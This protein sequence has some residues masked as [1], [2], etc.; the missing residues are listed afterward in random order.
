[1]LILNCL[2][3]SGAIN[4]HLGSSVAISSDGINIVV[5]APGVSSNRGAAYVY[6]RPGQSWFG[7]SK[8]VPD[9]TLTD[10]FS[11]TTDRVGSSV[12][13][14][15]DGSTIVAGA[16]DG[17]FCG[18]ALVFVRPGGSWSGVTKE[19][20]NATLFKLGSTFGDG[21]GYSVAISADGATI[22]A[23]AIGVNSNKGAAHVFVK[24]M[25]SDW[26]DDMTPDATLTNASAAAVEYLG[27][28]V[29]ISAD[30]STIVAGAD[31]VSG[32]KGAAYVYA[33]SGGSWINKSTP[34]AT[35]INSSGAANDFLG[36]S[37]AISGD[38]LTIVAGA[39]GVDGAYNNMGAA[40]VFFQQSNNANLS[41][42]VLSG[43]TLNPAFASGTTSYTADV[44]NSVASI[45]VTPTASDTNA[46]VRVNGT[47]VAS[48]SASGA[49]NLNVGAN[50][51]T[52]GVTAQDGVTTRTYTVTVTRA[53]FQSYLPL[54]MR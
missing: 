15:V 45:T 2:N 41:N 52:I 16:P 19:V 49:I 51:I 34:D 48:G 4:D 6:V 44:A 38:A 53:N 47:I 31:G 25:F 11:S 1:L 26:A 27:R 5:G 8:S 32:G 14:S 29:A 20:P 46:T 10:K 54:I 33:R 24:A 18:V 12:A 3:S 13:I 21:I 43:G 17:N 30:G 37:T 35:L 50:T 39:R 7:D 42:L 28:S 23:G 22:V 9:A 36:S 40:Y